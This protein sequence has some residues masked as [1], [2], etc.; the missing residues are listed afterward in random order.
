MNSVPTV[1]L[2][3]NSETKVAGIPFVTFVQA[4]LA[5]NLQH[6]HDAAWATSVDRIDVAGPDVVFH[7]RCSKAH[8]ALLRVDEC[9]VL[10]GLERGR[11]H[12]T[13]AGRR[14]EQAAGVLSRIR[15][16]FPETEVGGEAR[17]VPVTFWTLRHSS[18]C[19]ILRQLD[20]PSWDDIRLNYS[21]RTR[22]VLE[23]MMRGFSPGASGQL[24]LWTGE[25]GTG[26][27]TAVRALAWE[28]RAW[29]RLHYITDPEV[30]LGAGS[31]YLLEVL[32]DED[33]EDDV[34]PSTRRWRLLLMEDTGELLSADAKER[35]GQG[36][37]RLLNV[38]DG[39]IGQGLR[40]L[41]L[42]TTNEQVGRLHPAI[43]RPGRC[44]MLHEFD[45]LPVDE[46]NAWLAAQDATATVTRPT[47]IADLYAIRD[48]RERPRTAPIG[49]DG[50]GREAR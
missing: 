26:K 41:V 33:E 40:V 47:A 45:R 17:V 6:L 7:V 4:A 36:L 48:D 30:F 20:V 39:L 29:C 10:L 38:V 9:M 44:A 12:A 2:A 15:A 13:V 5:D 11:V 32:L 50:T 34:T 24:L 3:M 28:S 21:A 49:F 25:P 8:Y 23:S 27:T 16:A 46:A 37:S 22:R 19:A 14:D 35:S 42:V 1:T 31:P 18:P 43:S